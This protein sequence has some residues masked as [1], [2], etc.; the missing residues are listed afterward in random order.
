LWIEF[1]SARL[2]K[3]GFSPGVAYVSAMRNPSNEVKMNFTKR[4]IEILSLLLLFIVAVMLIF[5]VSAETADS[6][7]V[8]IFTIP[9]KTTIYDMKM[10][11][12]KSE[13][14]ID[15]DSLKIPE[16]VIAS[17]DAKKASGEIAKDSEI[18]DVICFN[19][20]IPDR[21]AE[22]TLP[23]TLYG[24]DYLLL[25]KRMNFENIDD[26]IDSYEGVISGIDDSHVV[27]TADMDNILCGFI[28]Y[29]GEYITISAI[30]ASEN[31]RT[32]GMPLHIVYS[33][34]DMLQPDEPI[35]FCGVKDQIQTPPLYEKI[36]KPAGSNSKGPYDT[37][38]VDVL[39]VTDNAFYSSSWVTTA[40]SYIA[41]ANSVTSYGRDDVKV[42]LVPL[43]DATHRFQLSANSSITTYPL[44]TLAYYYP[45]STLD[46]LDVDLCIYLGG[47]DITGEWNVAQGLS[48]GY[49]TRYA[50]SQMV[51]D[52]SGPVYNG[53]DYSRTYSIIHEIGHCFGAVH[54]QTYTWWLLNVRNTVMLSEY[55][56]YPFS[57][58]EFSSPSYNGDATHNNAQIIRNNKTSVSLYT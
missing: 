16:S 38:Y 13:S 30:Q 58:L 7:N 9:G 57:L 32:T 56:G 51:I 39:V 55:Y 50:W 15:Y 5:P 1:Q 21:Q 46:F 44:E 49:D 48:W 25:L 52:W 24:K 45:L 18:Y 43:Y 8:P 40:Q 37:V 11:T 35:E 20:P 10:I 27:L 19:N 34:Y 26:G 14:S 53:N 33:E 4:R 23:I 3:R 36:V 2:S 31:S 29:P 6:D 22:I 54:E 12:E 17:S 47:Y 41:T 28:S 42:V